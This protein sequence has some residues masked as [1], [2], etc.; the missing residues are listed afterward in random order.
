MSIVCIPE[1]FLQIVRN[2]P[3]KVAVLAE[4]NILLNV[5]IDA[6]VHVLDPVHR[7]TRMIQMDVDNVYAVL[8]V[9]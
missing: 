9:R 3:N 7:K 1:L 4:M 6:G 2:T 8:L 5:S